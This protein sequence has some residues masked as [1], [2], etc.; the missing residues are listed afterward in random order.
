M[1]REVPRL[2]VALDTRTTQEAIRLAHNTASIADGYEI[3][4]TLFH[5][6]ANRGI[7]PAFFVRQLPGGHIFLD[8]KLHGKPDQVGRMVGDIADTIQVPY[9]TYLTVDT[10]G[11]KKMLEVAVK[12]ARGKIQIIGLTVLT[13]LAKSDLLAETGVQC[14]EAADVV[15][16]RAHLAHDTKCQGVIVSPKEMARMRATYPNSDKFLLVGTAIRLPGDALMGQERAG[17]PEDACL[18]GADICIVGQPIINA[19][20]QAAK[21][22]AYKAAM[23]NGRLKRLELIS[24]STAVSV[25]P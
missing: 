16:R 14:I 25:R 11:G 18:D 4:N 2:F 20:D 24:K 9:L 12:A 3:G 13:S 15:H 10:A 8:F 1:Q 17:T 21:A 19:D 6:M 7:S 23:K 5:S 22:T